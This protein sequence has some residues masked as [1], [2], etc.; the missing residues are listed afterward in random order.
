MRLRNGVVI[1]AWLLG[2][3]AMADQASATFIRYES[4]SRSIT[5]TATDLLSGM[6]DTHSLSATNFGP[7]HESVS[8]MSPGGIGRGSASQNSVLDPDLGIRAD[9]NV[10]AL[11]SINQFQRGFGASDFHVTF[12]VLER[13]VAVVQFD[14]FAA[15]YGLSG[16]GVFVG[17]SPSFG[18]TEIVLEPGLYSMSAHAE[19]LN[20]S[21]SGSGAY[22]TARV[23]IPAP[24]VGVWA[25]VPAGFAVVRGRRRGG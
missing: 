7:F 8:A 16:P 19:F 2:S 14:S 5:A 12:T 24:G 10:S 22:V 1:A 20:N 15:T 13:V 25:L 18:P 4:Q 6:S 11:G 21:S 3:A 17:M 9:L 23:T